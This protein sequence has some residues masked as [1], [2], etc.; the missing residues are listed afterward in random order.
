MH[1]HRGFPSATCSCLLL[2]CD[3]PAMQNKRREARSNRPAVRS[4]NTRSRQLTTNRGDI[5]KNPTLSPRPDTAAPAG[6]N[7]E[8]LPFLLFLILVGVAG[9]IFRF[10]IFF[11]IDF[12]FG[13][14]FALLALQLFGLGRGVIAAALISTYTLILWN[15]PYACL[16]QTAEVAVVGWLYPRRKTGL[17]LADTLFWLCIGM[18]LV[19]LFYHGVMDVP[20]ENTRIDM[21]K[22]AVN[23]IANALLAR[24]LFVGY[25]LYS[26][27]QVIPL[28]E[29]V[30]TLLGFFVLCPALIILGVDSRADFITIDQRIRTTLLHDRDAIIE[31]LENWLNYR[32]NPIVTMAHLATTLSPQEMQFRLEQTLASDPNFQRVGFLDQTATTIAFA[33]RTDELGHSNIGRNYIDRPYIPLLKKTLQP[34]LSEVVIARIGPPQPVAHM[35]A[36][37]VKDSIYAGYIVGALKLGRIEKILGVNAAKEGGQRYTLL[38]RNGNSIASNDQ[39]QKA[40]TP[41]G[42]GLGEFY[43]LEEGLAQWIPTLPTNTPTS[44]RWGKSYY[45]TESSIGGLSEW[46]LILE[47][48]LAPFQK[49]L[50]DTYTRK[51]TLLFLILL[52]ALLLA[53]LLS[54]LITRSSEELLAITSDLPTRLSGGYSIAWPESSISETQRLIEIFRSMTAKLTEQFSAIRKLNLSLEERVEVRTQELSESRERYDLALLGSQDG[55]WEWNFLINKCYYS[56]RGFAMLGYAINDLEHTFATFEELIHPED[57]E[58]VRQHIHRHLQERIP[59][60]VEFR[61]RRK[62][63][64]YSWILGRGQALWNEQGDAVRMAGSHTDISERKK[65]EKLILTSLREKEVLLKEIHH[66]VKNNLQ[67]VYSLLALQANGIADSDIRTLF[68]ESR[69]RIASMALIHEKI[70]SSRDLAHIDFNHYL[71]ELVQNIAATY[72]RPEIKVVVEAESIFLDINCGIPCGLIVNELVSNSFKYAFPAG[73]NG[74][75]SIKMNC[76]AGGRYL[77]TVADNGSGI[78]VD[79]DFRKTTSLGLQLVTVLVGQLQGEIFLATDAGTRFSI[80]FPGPTP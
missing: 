15:H 51:L 25:T 63:G 64:E 80:S 16:I 26:R 70:Y 38:D 28:R 34:M 72:L 67:I 79:I 42:R 61:M 8:T 30:F 37:V 21:M 73:E 7:Q 35:L 76:A 45:F 1:S 57:R 18:P 56:G 55:I 6:T 33:P 23:G 4:P 43:R 14:I 52:S 50:Y 65:S 32:N 41:M 47:Q 71:Q 9:N 53:E 40:M 10:P 22:Q 49:Q 58:N 13:S 36:P 3:P 12:L 29:I 69:N 68:D 39:E 17:V 48:P 27:A 60:C 46:E 62:D 75:I 5:V 2:L 54:R 77:L 24:L 20:W 59:Y 78:P 74:Q 31:R 11:D 66:R 44:E 19:Y